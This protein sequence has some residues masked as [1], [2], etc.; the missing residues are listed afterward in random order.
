MTKGERDSSDKTERRD[1]MV[2]GLTRSKVGKENL[3]RDMRDLG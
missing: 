3:V 1:D 2:I